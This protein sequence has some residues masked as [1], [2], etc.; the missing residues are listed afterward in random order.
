MKHDEHSTWKRLEELKAE[1]DRLSACYN[2]GLD[3]EL[4]RKRIALLV[5]ENMNLSLECD[6]LKRDRER[7]TDHV[8]DNKILSQIVA[9]QYQTIKELQERIVE[10]EQENRRLSERT[11]GRREIQRARYRAALMDIRREGKF[12]CT[13]STAYYM[14]VIAR[15]ALEGADDEQ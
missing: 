2:N 6:E 11:D 7:R 9:D 15:D 4:L 8:C 12:A 14:D 3:P 5:H 1:R 10:L 13:G